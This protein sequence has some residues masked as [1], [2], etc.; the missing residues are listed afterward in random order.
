MKTTVIKVALMIFLNIVVSCSDYETGFKNGF[1]GIKYNKWI[2][3][4]REDYMK[5][6]EEGVYA[7]KLDRK[8]ETFCNDLKENKPGEYKYHCLDK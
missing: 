1:K 2:L 4:G 8:F 6:Y 5:G 3:F 7:G